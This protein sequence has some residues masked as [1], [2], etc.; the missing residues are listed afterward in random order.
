M[1]D[2]LSLVGVIRCTLQNFQFLKLC[3]S[4]SFHP[5]HLNFIQGIL[6]MGQ[7][8][9]LLFWAICQKFKKKN[10]WHFKIYGILKFFF[11]QDHMQLE[12]SKC[13]FSQR[14]L[15]AMVNLNARCWNTAMRSWHI[16]PN[17]IYSI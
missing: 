15:V 2:S 13:Y 10:I 9:L 11:T 14:T 1:P 12:I 16:V 6:I 5:I 3:C 7:Y 4:L 17:M 8:R